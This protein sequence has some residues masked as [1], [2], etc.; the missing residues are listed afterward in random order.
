MGHIY[1]KQGNIYSKSFAP[2]SEHNVG[3]RFVKVQVKT[4]TI[5]F[6]LLTGL[7]LS[8][9]LTKQAP[10]LEIRAA[11]STPAEYCSF[12]TWQ[13]V[14]DWL[15]GNNRLGTE[16][17]LYAPGDA[18]YEEKKDWIGP[19]EVIAKGA[20]VA[21]IHYNKDG[22][23]RQTFTHG[24]KMPVSYNPSND[25]MRFE[26]S[27]N[28]KAE[29]SW[30]RFLRRMD[31]SY[32][33]TYSSEMSQKQ[34]SLGVLQK[35]EIMRIARDA[36]HT[37]SGGFSSAADADNKIKQFEA[38]QLKGSSSNNYTD[39]NP[40]RLNG[41]TLTDQNISSIIGFDISGFDL[42]LYESANPEKRKANMIAESAACGSSIPT[43]QPTATT[44]VSCEEHLMVPP[45]DFSTNVP[46]FSPNVC[47][48][49]IANQFATATGRT[50]LDVCGM[51]WVTQWCNGNK[52]NATFACRGWSQS[53]EN[54]VLVN[55]TNRI[56]AITTTKE[57]EGDGGQL[58]SNIATYGD[59][60]GRR[61]TWNNLMREVQQGKIA[62][63]YE[64]HNASKSPEEIRDN[65]LQAAAVA[66]F[67]KPWGAVKEQ[68]RLNNCSVAWDNAVSS[69]KSVTTVSV[70]PST[71]TPTLNPTTTASPTSVFVPSPTPTPSTALVSTTAELTNTVSQ[72]PTPATTS[73]NSSILQPIVTF[74]NHVY[75]FSTED[76]KLKI[77][78]D[79]LT[80][81]LL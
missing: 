51:Y 36:I 64:F 47:G 63:P 44:P 34:I 21:T 55:Y 43:P 60:R 9:L 52:Q 54:P 31:D 2:Q 76:G 28:V 1:T 53:E 71:P 22:S 70:V 25:D 29:S 32:F 24:G 48:E 33:G 20:A 30:S 39:G 7:L 26:F 79:N 4:L 81:T 57:A 14:G 59:T 15:K 45:A 66:I 27:G 37:L 72:E 40:D 11:E 80:C 6:L 18:D 68:E 56:R 17:N 12:E 23:I 49:H 65:A 41:V 61:I 16:K 74:N 38:R 77:C 8:V 19:G 3:I 46:N 10:H 13:T 62:F 69:P 67:G 75:T 73:T 35:Y 50:E 78:K 5:S 42:T 58:A